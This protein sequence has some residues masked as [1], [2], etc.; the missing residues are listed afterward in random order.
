MSANIKILVLSI[1]GA[2][3]SK[4]FKKRSSRKR[5][6]SIRVLNGCR[7]CA[8]GRALFAFAKR[9]TA[10]QSISSKKGIFINYCYLLMYVYSFCTF[11]LLF[12]PYK[13][14]YVHAAHYLIYLSTIIL[15]LKG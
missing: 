4:L 5:E 14:I 2:L 10:H 13:D 7:F 15:A 11:A 8:N 9:T 3:S 6:H 12:W 1:T